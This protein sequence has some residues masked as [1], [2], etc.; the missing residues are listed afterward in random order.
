MDLWYLAAEPTTTSYIILFHS[1]SFHLIPYLNLSCW[2]VITFLS[3]LSLSLSLS[4]SLCYLL[5]HFSSLILCTYLV[6]IPPGI[7]TRVALI[8]IS[9]QALLRPP[10]MPPLGIISLK[11]LI[12]FDVVLHFMVCL[13]IS[14]RILIYFFCFF[15]S[16]SPWSSSLHSLSLWKLFSLLKSFYWLF[17]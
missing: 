17:N 14:L 16:N 8:K 4:L 12:S 15:L 7:V 9:F 10:A 2:I 5:L 3:A 11:V 1:V 6:I 13:S